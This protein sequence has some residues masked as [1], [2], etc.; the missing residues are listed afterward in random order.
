[1]KG[2]LH[3]SENATWKAFTLR[4]RR[5]LESLPSPFFR[6]NMED[7][8][9]PSTWKCVNTRLRPLDGVHTGDELYSFQMILQ[10][11]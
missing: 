3:P 8:N 6:V 7:T 1:M 4:R 2:T 5:Q 10:H 9:P 11:S